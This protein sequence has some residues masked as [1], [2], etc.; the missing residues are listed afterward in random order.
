[1]SL[2]V[3]KFITRDIWQM[4]V[5]GHEHETLNADIFSTTRFKIMGVLQIPF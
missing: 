3:G 5:V 2:H 4:N 1:M